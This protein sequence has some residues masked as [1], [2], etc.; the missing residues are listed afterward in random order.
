LYQANGLR[1]S[2]FTTISEWATRTMERHHEL[3]SQ[4]QLCLWDVYS[5][6]PDSIGAGIHK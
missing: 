4:S 2:S 1:S 3:A 6:G 5:A